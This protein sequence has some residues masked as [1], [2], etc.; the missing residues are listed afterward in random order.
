MEMKFRMKFDNERGCDYFKRWLAPEPAERKN[1]KSDGAREHLFESIEEVLLKHEKKAK[2]LEAANLANQKLERN[3]IVMQRELEE[4]KNKL[5][6]E[7]ER[8][9]VRLNF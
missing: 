2:E 3:I 5:I 4:F 9:K 8:N 1:A 7:R 6:L